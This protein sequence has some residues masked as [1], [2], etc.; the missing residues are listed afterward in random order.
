MNPT[1]AS[2]CPGTLFVDDT[3]NGAL[4][5][6]LTVAA[7][8]ETN[9]LL[10]RYVSTDKRL[11]TLSAVLYTSTSAMSPSQPLSIVPG[12]GSSRP[13][14]VTA[15]ISYLYGVIPLVVLGGFVRGGR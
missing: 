3:L 5:A 12:E 9:H 14:T 11:P 7:T 15:G 4:M 1:M 8:L 6:L 10:V 2:S 13:P